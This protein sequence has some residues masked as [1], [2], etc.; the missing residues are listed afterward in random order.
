MKSKTYSR[1]AHLSLFIAI[2]CMFLPLPL[3]IILDPTQQGI[4]HLEVFLFFAS[5][6]LVS[7]PF[8]FKAM[9]LSS[10]SRNME[11]AA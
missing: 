11:D 5:G 1:L 9:L 4:S 7:I 10:K 3:F 8:S 6:V 2:F